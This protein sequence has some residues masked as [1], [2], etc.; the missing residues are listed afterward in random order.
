M[1]L[2]DFP[3]C[4]PPVAG[5]PTVRDVCARILGPLG[6]PVVFGAPIGHTARPMLT[7]PLGVNARLQAHAAG[8]LEILEAA[9]IR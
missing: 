7:I 2:G 8:N 6:V 9:V 3:E 1:V 5:S 4:D